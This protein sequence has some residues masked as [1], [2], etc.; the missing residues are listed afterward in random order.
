MSK[1]P[2]TSTF[3]FKAP[4]PASAATPSSSSTPSSPTS[5]HLKQ[6]RVSL[7]LPS[8]PRVVQAWTFRDDT[9][10]DFHVPETE[11]AHELMPVKRGKMRKIAVTDE[12]D[13]DVTGA[14]KEKRQRKKWSAEETQ[15]LV[16]GC[17]RVCFLI[18]PP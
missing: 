7:A 4:F 11:T 12:A 17:N 10:L 13:V 18:F 15:M 9:G 16:D 6:R 14:E 1:T 8:A 5:S 2:Y 3:S